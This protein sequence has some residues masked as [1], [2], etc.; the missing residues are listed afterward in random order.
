MSALK[1]AGMDHVLVVVGGVIPPQDYQ[2]LYDIGEQ[3]MGAREGYV[4]LKV[5]GVSRV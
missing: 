2:E 3:G 5:A 4:G 1:D